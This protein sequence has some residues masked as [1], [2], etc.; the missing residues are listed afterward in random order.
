MGLRR[1]VSVLAATGLLILG[2]GAIFVA[3]AP[4]RWVPGVGAF[5]GTFV[6]LGFVMSSL[7]SGEGTGNLTGEAG[8]GGSMGT[9]LQLVGVITALVA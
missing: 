2:A 1:R 9:V 4:W 7:V 5:L 3:L 6:I 8:V